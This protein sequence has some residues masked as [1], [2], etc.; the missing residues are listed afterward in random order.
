MIEDPSRLSHWFPIVAEALPESRY[1]KT[2]IVPAPCDLTCVLD[3][4][5]PPCFDTLRF[6]LDF[7]AR[8]LGGYP[9]FLRHDLCSAKHDWAKTCYVPDAESLASHL[10]ASIEYW[11]MANW[12]AN[13]GD[14][15]WIVREYVPVWPAVMTAFEGM[16]IGPERRYIVRDG[17]VTDHFPYWPLTALWNRIPDAYFVLDDAPLK[18]ARLASPA[19]VRSEQFPH[20]VAR[21]VGPIS[22]ESPEEIAELTELA[23]IVGAALGGAW[24]IDF[25]HTARGWLLIDC[26]LAAE[27]W[28]ASDED[29][30]SWAEAIALTR[31]AV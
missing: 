24:S 3:G 2:W 8:D 1:P 12:F 18:P 31:P 7:A 22:Y 27:S 21:N 11:H 14:D 19:P 28:I 23:E 26:A 9:V 13:G 4:K 17:R 20:A 25:M 30:A 6:S 29:R 5:E 10:V 15:V 16:P